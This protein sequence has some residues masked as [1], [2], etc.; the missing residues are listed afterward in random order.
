MDKEERSGQI[1]NLSPGDGITLTCITCPVGCELEVTLEGEGEVRV[2]NN[3]CPR[4]VDY[5]V[6]ETTAPER[7]FTSTVKLRGSSLERRLPVRLDRVIAKA[8][9]LEVAEYVRTLEA[10]VPVTMGDVL[11]DDLLKLG[12]NLVASRSVKE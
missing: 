12:A 7:T 1:S 8:R 3:R 5:A 2:L 9:L 10:Q 6:Q 4:G 11:Q